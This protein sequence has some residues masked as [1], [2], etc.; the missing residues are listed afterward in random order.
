MPHFPFS[1]ATLKQGWGGGID[2]VRKL[3]W[4][5]VGQRKDWAMNGWE[6]VREVCAVPVPWVIK[7]LL[8][9]ARLTHFS[10]SSNW[11]RQLLYELGASEFYTKNNIYMNLQA[12]ESASW[13]LANELCCLLAI[14][15]RDLMTILLLVL[16]QISFPAS[17]PL[18]CLFHLF[19]S[20][21]LENSSKV[22][23][24]HTH[25]KFQYTYIYWKAPVNVV[26]LRHPHTMYQLLNKKMIPSIFTLIFS[27]GAPCLNN[28]ILLYCQSFLAF[29]FII[30]LS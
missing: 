21:Q 20:R 10:F 18:G 4:K 15:L 26:C 9:W 5:R 7:S 8:P 3:D 28:V 14:L 12:F 1:L 13:L 16:L 2:W 23:F 19:F 30:L 24:N 22:Y 25:E 11:M 17:L 6:T 29:V 27:V